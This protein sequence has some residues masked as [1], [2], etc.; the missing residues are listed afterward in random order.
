MLCV[1]CNSDKI[2]ILGNSKVICDLSNIE[3]ER[4]I[5]YIELPIWYT[6]K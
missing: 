6:K 4:L 3:D 5:T 1:V 2:T